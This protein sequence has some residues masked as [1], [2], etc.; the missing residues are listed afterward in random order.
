MIEPPSGWL[1][2]IAYA[3]TVTFP[4]GVRL[5]ASKTLPVI[6]P[7]IGELCDRVGTGIPIANSDAAQLSA[8]AKRNGL[9]VI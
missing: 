8:T 4:R 7:M 1:W 2:V 3:R 5:S 9:V 6:D